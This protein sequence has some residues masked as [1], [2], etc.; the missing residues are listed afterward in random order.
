MCRKA[1]SLKNIMFSRLQFGKMV[2]RYDPNTNHIAIL[3]YGFTLT[4]RLEF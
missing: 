4:V 2:E 3:P 1:K